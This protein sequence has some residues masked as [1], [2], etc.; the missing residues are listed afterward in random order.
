MSNTV[1]KKSPKKFGGTCRCPICGEK[2]AGSKNS[3]IYRENGV[4]LN[5]SGRSVDFGNDKKSARKLVRSRMKRELLQ[6]EL[7]F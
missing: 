2:N 4:V 3:R 5:E 1:R 7:E 6:F